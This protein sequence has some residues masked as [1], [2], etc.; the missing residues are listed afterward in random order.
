MINNKKSNQIKILNILSYAI[1]F[2]LPFKFQV[3]LFEEQNL[4]LYFFFFLSIFIGLYFYL[5]PKNPISVLFFVETLIL[6]SLISIVLKT[7][8]PFGLALFFFFGYCITKY[9]SPTIRF[10]LNNL[11]ILNT[12]LMLFQ[13]CGDFPKLHE[14]QFYSEK[15]PVNVHNLGDI[16]PLSQLRPPGIFPSTI[17]LSL[18]QI[19]CVSFFLIEQKPVSFAETIYLVSFL[20]LAQSTTS[21]ILFLII[22]FLLI[23]KQ[24]KIIAVLIVF[25]IYYFFLPKKFLH[26]N[27]NLNEFMVSVNSRLSFMETIP[28]NSQFTLIFSSIILFVIICGLI[29]N[30]K[31][32]YKVVLI[33][34]LILTLFLH[35]L[36]FSAFYWLFLGAVV[37]FLKSKK[38][39][40]CCKKIVLKN[41]MITNLK[42]IGQPKSN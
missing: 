25:C 35:S 31:K 39:N 20:S 28:A 24:K 10:C 14:F 29:K 34:L 18:F 13:I 26:Y 36:A 42:I 7:P 23:R 4:R 32:R 11:I 5:L 38:I 41:R 8:K 3:D 9:N 21:V 22:F 33:S 16:I 40:N 12:V 1:I 17:Y 2:I 37:F 30:R 15:I 19:F 6:V 27:F